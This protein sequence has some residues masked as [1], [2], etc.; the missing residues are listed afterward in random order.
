M[1]IKEELHSIILAAGRGSRMKH[2]TSNLPK[3]R[4]I[5][6]D[7]EL[8][9]WQFDSLR[10]ANISNI[11][12]VTGYL[13]HTFKYTVTYF[14]N[15]NW[16]NTN[17]LSSLMKASSWLDK[18]VCIISYS[19]IV[20]SQDAVSVV[21]EST[22][23]IV[24]AYDPNWFRLWNMR[25]QNPLIDAETFEFKNNILLEIGDKTDNIKN[26]QGQYM[27]LI[28]ITPTGWLTIKSY[29]SKIKLE[30]INKLD[31]TSF[32][33]ILINEGIIINV[34]PINDNWYEIDSESDLNVY[35]SLKKLW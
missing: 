13:S 21:A 35:E 9:D 31:I 8:I 12:I 18:H 24:I 34:V 32:L 15:K 19:D 6:H 33:K 7:K 23:D 10:S 20:F 11:A 3:C 14:H 17:M 5:L 25:F 1:K 4:T 16:E 26:I 30:I 2:L 28:K 22:G 27:G 29:L